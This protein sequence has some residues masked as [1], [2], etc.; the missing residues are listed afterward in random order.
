MDDP[1]KV[2]SVCILTLSDNAIVFGEIKPRGEH[3]KQRCLKF[4]WII[5]QC[6]TGP[7]SSLD[8]LSRDRSY[9]RREEGCAERQEVTHRLL[10]GSF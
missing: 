9:D 8:R 1:E 3:L 4:A 6:F 7:W 10:S 5:A 2:E